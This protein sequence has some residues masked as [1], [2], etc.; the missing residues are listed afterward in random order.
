MKTLRWYQGDTVQSFFDYFDKN[1]GNPL[2]INWTGTGKS[3]IIAEFI[4]RAF[5]LS[6][7]Q[8]MLVL[9]H[10]K[11]IIKQDYLEFVEHAPNIDVGIYSAGLRLKQANNSVIFGTNKSVVNGL[12]ELGVFDLI[13]IDECFPEGTLID[14]RPIESIKPG[15]YVRSFNHQEQQIEYKQVIGTSVRSSK[16]MCFL[17]L[18]NGDIIAVT[19]NHPFWTGTHY[20][21]A[22][23]IEV[24]SFLYALQKTGICT[25]NKSNK[26]VSTNDKKIWSGAYLLQQRM[27]DDNKIKIK[28]CSDET[29]QSDERCKN[30]R[31]N[32]QYVTQN[33]TYAHNT[34]RERN[35]SN[36]SRKNVIRTIR[37]RLGTHIYSEHTWW[38]S[39]RIPNT[40]QNRSS[41]SDIKDSNRNRWGESL[42]VETSNARQEENGIFTKIRVVGISF[43]EF[44]DTEQYRVY[45]LHVEGNNNY[46]VTQSNYLVHN[47]HL[48]PSK[49]E[50]IYRTII[51]HFIDCNPYCKILGFTASPWRMDQGHLLEGD[52]PIFTHVCYNGFN[53]L[54]RLIEEGYLAPLV[55]PKVAIKY[56]LSK[57]PII[58]NEYSLKA[59]SDILTGNDA[60]TECVIDEIVSQGEDRRSWLLFCPTIEHSAYIHEKL[61]RRGVRSGL[62]HSKLSYKERD[63]VIRRYKNYELQALVNVDIA[64]IGFDHKGVDLIVLLMKTNSIPKYLQVLGRGFRIE[65]NKVDCKVLDFVGNIDQHGPVNEIDINVRP[66]KKGVWNVKGA[67]VHACEQCGNLIAISSTTC[68]DCGNEIVRQINFKDTISIAPIISD[69]K[70]DGKRYEVSSIRYSKYYKNKTGKPCIRVD[71]YDDIRIVVSEFIFPESSGELNK[72]ASIWWLKRFKASLPLTVDSCFKKFDAGE[73]KQE[74]Q[75]IW[76]KRSNGYYKIVHEEFGEPK[77]KKKSALGNLAKIFGFK[78]G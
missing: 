22:R 52:D 1:D 34:K 59:Q 50:G 77:P 56:D 65:E 25:N 53:D 57:I 73:L 31:E 21:P 64:T 18:E 74:P 71:Y 17:S 51:K 23:N 58:G 28:F 69:N 5:A 62:L 76:I 2:A 78:Y 75:V 44:N 66:K 29:K 37:P 33:S 61:L 26:I 10:T 20:E 72:I 46:F 7:T 68:P 40:L 27:F 38:T 35:R 49:G 47:C 45:N 39:F 16:H 6:S 14:G 9:S 43:Q 36:K 3:L 70:I 12:N 60:K 24:G 41:S 11:E 19:P 67:P 42:F 15:E 30:K 55:T 4:K 54:L 63:R 8:R 13:L 32:G 48:T